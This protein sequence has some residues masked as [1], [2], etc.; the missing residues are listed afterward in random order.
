MQPYVYVSRLRLRLFSRIH[1]RRA[2]RSYREA[3][4]TT[5]S[6]SAITGL[7]PHEHPDDYW[8]WYY[9]DEPTGFR[10]VAPYTGVVHNGRLYRSGFSILDVHEIVPGS[11][12]P[13]GAERDARADSG[14]DG[15]GTDSADA[16][17]PMTSGCSCRLSPP[18]K[19]STL[20]FLAALAAV[21][22]LL[23]RR[24]R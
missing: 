6:V 18:G 8:G 7:T 4:G 19:Q 23:R 20:G 22:L 9:Q 3:A 14:A 1:F 13:V 24:W 15:P 10:G 11:E 21:G 12:P 5:V 17:A 16:L 2:S